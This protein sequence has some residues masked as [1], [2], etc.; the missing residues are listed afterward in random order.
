MNSHSSTFFFIMSFCFLI[1]TIASRSCIDLLMH[2]STSCMIISLILVSKEK[3]SGCVSK[4]S[5]KMIMKKGYLG[6]VECLFSLYLL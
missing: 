2:G 3:K 6:N 5:M 4:R 1:S